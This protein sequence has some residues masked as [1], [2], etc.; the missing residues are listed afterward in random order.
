MKHTFL[1]SH[2]FCVAILKDRE[3][4]RDVLIEL[5]RDSLSNL[6]Y[7]Q[8]ET[9]SL[10]VSILKAFS[11]I[12]ANRLFWTEF[13]LFSEW[14]RDNNIDKKIFTIWPS[15]LFIWNSNKITIHNRNIYNNLRRE[16]AWSEIKRWSITIASFKFNEFHH[17]KMRRNNVW[18]ALN[19]CLSGI[20]FLLSLF[21]SAELLHY[22]QQWI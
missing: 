22:L 5:S 21:L 6:K 20:R 10:N 11:S 14:T 4:E 13:L 2:R 3:R 8:M 1:C 18:I 7:L 17:F 12:S 16:I 19:L 9:G 15:N